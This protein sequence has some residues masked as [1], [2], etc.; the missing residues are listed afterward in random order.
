MIVT[1]GRIVLFRSR[2]GAYTVPAIVTA[3]PETLAPIG[4]E[5]FTE[6]DGQRGVP[7]LLGPDRVHLTVL[8]PG[9]P[10]QRATADDF[11][12]VSDLPVQ[13]NT[14]GSY[15]EWNIP[16][17]DPAESGVPAEILADYAGLLGQQ[18]PGS[19]MMPPRV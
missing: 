17:W 1:I 6:S 16:R 4:V 7:P 10:G 9:L 13:E 8:T 11:E 18:P 12:V 5:M 15:Q 19:W 2:T 14:G 3:T